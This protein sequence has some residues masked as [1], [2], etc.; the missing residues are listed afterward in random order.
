MTLKVSVN[1]RY[2]KMVLNST[3]MNKK[4]GKGNQIFAYLTF[5]YVAGKLKIFVIGAADV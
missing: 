1:N 2:L 4:L 5:Q 3:K